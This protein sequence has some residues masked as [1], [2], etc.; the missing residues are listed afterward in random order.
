MDDEIN[1]DFQLATKEILIKWL[2]GIS[3]LNN[4]MKKAF[5]Y[6]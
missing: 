5:E 6:L 4:R 3:F 1:V 2:A